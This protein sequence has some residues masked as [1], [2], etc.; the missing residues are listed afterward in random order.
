METRKMDLQVER[1]KP[2]LGAR[3]GLDRARIGEAQ[4]GEQMLALL[5]EHKV[6]VF[7]RIGLSDAEQL[8]LT[9]SLGARQT[10]PKLVAEDD[11][12]AEGVYTITLDP[13]SILEPE[14]ILGT[15]FWHMDGL[16][17]QPPPPKATVLT[18]RRVASKGGQTEFANVQAAYEGLSA[19]EKAEFEALRVMHTVTASVREVAAPEELDPKRRDLRHEHPLVWK[20]KNG[21]KS[22]VVGYTADYVVGQTKAE[23]RALLARLL[24]WTAQPAF[25]YRHH[26]QEGDLVIWDN[27][28]TLHRVIPYAPDSGR[29]MHRTSVAGLEA[30]G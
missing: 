17:M 28:A 13:K 25:T 24:E 20:R 3:I 16:T 14:Y 4:L 15:F 18:A 10:F 6:L 8:A 22:L 29:K 2:A 19:E 30:V 11:D 5:D 12:A 23:G 21:R 26:W 9:E 1:I 27:T 7:P